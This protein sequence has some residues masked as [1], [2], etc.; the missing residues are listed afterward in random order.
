MKLDKIYLRITALLNGLEVHYDYVVSP[1]IDDL[2]DEK[3]FR[4]VQKSFA[5]NSARKPK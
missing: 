1:N 5:P 3:T 4:L 2:T